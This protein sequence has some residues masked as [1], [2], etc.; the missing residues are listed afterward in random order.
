MHNILASRG[1]Q[2]VYVEESNRV[3]MQQSVYADSTSNAG[4]LGAM[5]PGETVTR[6][7]GIP[8]AGGA[9]SVY[10]QPPSGAGAQ[11]TTSV[12]FVR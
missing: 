3:P 12:Y 6:V 11:G 2:S 9:Q 1:Q 7:G 4:R 5:V 10:I 8:N